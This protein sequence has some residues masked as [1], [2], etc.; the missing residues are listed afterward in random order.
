MVIGNEDKIC[1]LFHYS[2]SLVQPVAQ[3]FRAKEKG[4]IEGKINHLQR[5]DFAMYV[6][7]RQL[8]SW[9]CK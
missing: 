4:E 9:N 8:N 1:S 3:N 7:I 6:H 2:V 5:G